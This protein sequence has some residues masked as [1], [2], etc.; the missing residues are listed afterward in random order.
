LAD[1]FVLPTRSEN[2]GLVVTEAL[3]C[4]VP[5]ITTK[6]APWSE[7]LGNSDSS[8]VLKCGISEVSDCEDGTNNFRTLELQN[9]RIAPDRCG[10]WVDVN[11]EALAVALKEA[12]DL[13]DEERQAMGENGRRLVERKYRWETVGARMVEMYEKCVNA[14]MR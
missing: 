13:T 3:A 8:R 14:R 9:F 10:W 7:L 4:G 11:V 12:M 2:F 1:V 5:V 6:G